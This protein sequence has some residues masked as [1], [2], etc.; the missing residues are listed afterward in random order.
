[1]MEEI[2]YGQAVRDAMR[3]EM[4][5]NPDVF[6]MGEDI[7][8]YGG[9][10]G[11]TYGMLD[12][13]GCERVRDTPIAEAGIVGV[14]VGAAMV[15]MRPI[16]EIMF[17]DF[18]TLASDQLMNQAAKIHYML[19][20]RAKIP[21]VVRTPGGSGTGAAAQH[22]QSLEALFVHIPGL[23]VVMPST[24]YDAKGLLKTAIR[25]DNPVV[26]FEHKLLYSKKGFVPAEDYTVPFGVAEIVRK[27]RDI[28][29]V[30]TSIMVY[31]ALEAAEMLAGE[32]IEAEIIDPR[33]LVPLDLETI[34][35]S[36]KKTGKLMI[37]QEACKRGGFASEVAAEVIESEAFGYLDAPISRLAGKNIPIPYSQYLEKA[38]VP[39]VEDI[40]AAV[41]NVLI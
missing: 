41:K 2:T 14:G 29:L 37:I 25:D 33:T 4:H 35:T 12:E 23:K 22:S 26:F 15:G 20:G 32:G 18:L 7:G 13:F 10:F 1:M 3:E 24:P 21:L 28:T 40:V 27:G 34:V 16:V 31:R 17:S 8:V 36:V 30:A 19:G 6:I 5:N 39:Q 11:I 38:A 9:A